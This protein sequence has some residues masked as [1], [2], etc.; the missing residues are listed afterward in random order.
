MLIQDFMKA[1]KIS[2][3]SINEDLNYEERFAPLRSIYLGKNKQGL[4]TYKE[5]EDIEWNYEIYGLE[6]I[7][8]EIDNL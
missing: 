6:S 8:K 4:I 2:K 5:I 1:N 3:K 7:E